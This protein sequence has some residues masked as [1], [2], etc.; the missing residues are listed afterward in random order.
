M[1][2]R[3]TTCK[4]NFCILVPPKNEGRRFCSNFSAAV[5]VNVNVPWLH[6]WL[7]SCNHRRQHFW[8]SSISQIHASPVERLWKHLITRNSFICTTAT[9]CDPRNINGLPLMPGRCW[10]GSPRCR[11]YMR[12][13]IYS[14]IS[15]STYQKGVLSI[16]L[17]ISKPVMGYTSKIIKR[18]RISCI[19]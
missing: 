17:A 2:H 6:L 1:H 18:R 7:L 9:L 15:P 3:I 14:I 19:L 16:R 5:C 12:A 11:N 8:Q 13:D 10:I 4:E